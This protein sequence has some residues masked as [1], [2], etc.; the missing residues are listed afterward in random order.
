[1]L[2]FAPLPT[3]RYPEWLAGYSIASLTILYTLVG[4][5]SA[6]YLLV[7]VLKKTGRFTA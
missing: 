2:L 4:L 6:L 5:L 3:L 7:R 1:M